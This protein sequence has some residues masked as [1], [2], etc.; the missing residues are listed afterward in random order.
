M[1]RPPPTPKAIAILLV[2]DDPDCRMLVRDAIN[3]SKVRNAVFEVADGQ[4]ALDFLN[5]R[6]EWAN[7][8]RPGLVYLDIEMPV[9]NGLETL[10]EIKQTPELR[11]IPVVMMTGV[12]D[13]AQMFQAAEAGANSYTIKPAN[14]E[15][16]LKTVLTSTN[17]WLTIHQYPDHHVAPDQA[18]R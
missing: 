16:F 15:Q 8:P 6:G 13:E 5:R 14:A 4:E 3:D 9:K 11:N 17:Y 7:A 18:R 12:C 10:R 2:D 1:R